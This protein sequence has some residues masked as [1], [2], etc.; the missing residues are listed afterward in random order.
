MNRI[1]IITALAI[2]I[3]LSPRIAFAEG[4]VAIAD[5][6]DVAKDGYSSGISYNFQT[7][8]AA[9]ERALRECRSSPDAPPKTRELCKLVR[10]F[11]NQC[12]AVALDP[13]AGTPG[14]GWAI[15][16]T[17]VLARRD[18]LRV[19]EDTA[20]RD[21]QGKCVVTAEGCDGSAK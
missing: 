1:I 14:A 9:E 3:V 12:A 20:G 5:P 15:G 13:E 21:R 2:L 10:N 17:L 4:A 6:G 16:E 11:R 8:E 18:A 7:S 19:C